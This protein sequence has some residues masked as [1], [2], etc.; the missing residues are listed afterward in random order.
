MTEPTTRP[1]GQTGPG[2]PPASPGNRWRTPALVLVALAL[3]IGVVATVAL[4]ASNRNAAPAP[5][6]TE[7]PVAQRSSDTAQ[8]TPQT[9]A[10][11]EVADRAAVEAAWANFW[12]V[13]LTLVAQFPPAEWPAKVGRVA[14]DPIR[15]QQLAVS[16]KDLRDGVERYGTVVNRPS[17][18]QPIAGKNTATLQDC[19]DGSRAGS[20]NKNTGKKVTVGTPRASTRAIF[21]KGGDGQWR[22]QRIEDHVDEKC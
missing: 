5:N 10:Q 1:A 21:V 18:P 16:A 20:V 12:V 8:P 4:V 22:V 7:P 9:P 2:M 17:W 14:V 13:S 15:S 11:R 3:V 19:M 6:T